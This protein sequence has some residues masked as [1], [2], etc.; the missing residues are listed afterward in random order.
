MYDL[1]QLQTIVAIIA[2][3]SVG[4]FCHFPGE[5]TLRLLEKP[6]LP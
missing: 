4:S 6:L 2:R 1:V 3:L 5:L